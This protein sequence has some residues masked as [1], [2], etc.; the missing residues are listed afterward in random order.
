MVYIRSVSVKD[1]ECEL[2]M[3]DESN[4]V[5]KRYGKSAAFN[6]GIGGKS[7]TE[8]KYF[9]VMRGDEE[10]PVYGRPTLKTLFGSHVDLVLTP[11]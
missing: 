11:R 10:C 2:V 3:K 6:W 8:I 5:V 1:G 9:R 4:N 7:D